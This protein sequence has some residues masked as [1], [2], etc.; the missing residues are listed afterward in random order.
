MVQAKIRRVT[1]ADKE[2]LFI[3]ANDP[4]TRE[5]SFSKE[6]ISW[7]NHCAWFAQKMQDGSCYHYIL[8][9]DNEPVGVLRLDCCEAVCGENAYR[10]SYSVAPGQRGH[11]YGKKLLQFAEYH[12]VTDIPGCAVLLGEVK[13]KNT[14]SVKCFEST[15]FDRTE[16]WDD[17]NVDGREKELCFKKH[18]D[19]KA[20]VV[21]RADANAAVGNGH[22]M[23]CLTIADACFKVGMYP[24]FVCAGPDAKALIQDRG[25]AVEVLGTDYRK[26]TEELCE[27]KEWI[28]A[29]SFVVL[30]SYY[31]NKEYVNALR[32]KGYQTV[33]LDDT[34][35][36]KYEVDLLINY[37][38]YA[39]EL[40]YENRYED[41]HTKCLLGAAYAPVRPAFYKK[42]YQVRNH[43]ERVMVTTGAA[44]PYRVGFFFAEELAK[45]GLVK[46]IDVVCGP[47]HDDVLRLQKLATRVGENGQTQIKILQNL[48]DLSDA[49]YHSDLV[50]AAAGGTLYELCAV[51]VPAFTYLFADNQR[52]GALAFAKQAKSVCLGDVRTDIDRMREVLCEEIKKYQSFACRE[53]LSRYMREVSDGHGA[54]RIAEIMK[55]FWE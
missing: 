36:Q 34:G 27:W 50:I 46:E 53:A 5:Q 38:L 23:R 48:S 32:K 3:W 6:P 33:W 22:V 44:D 41:E 42:G 10:I 45:S 35:E 16:I 7:E 14:A 40:G 17:G 19:R 13:E 8:E 39:T 24:I 37:N 55:R 29:G 15:G 30:D 18:L 9:V 31:L 20:C 21:F 28:P 11:G 54:E 25:Y 52:Q 51:G 26:M 1:E 4:V 2:R 49:M 12:A 47:Y 43:L